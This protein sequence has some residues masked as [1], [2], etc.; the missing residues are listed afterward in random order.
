MPR[1]AVPEKDKSGNKAMVAQSENQDGWIKVGKRKSQCATQKYVKFDAQ[2]ASKSHRS[3]PPIKNAALACLTD[4]I[5]DRSRVFSEV[6]TPEHPLFSRSENKEGTP[7]VGVDGVAEEVEKGKN[8]VPPG[9]SYGLGVPAPFRELAI[10]VEASDLGP[11]I[12]A[13]D[14]GD[15]ALA[16]AIT[17]DVAGDGIAILGDTPSRLPLKGVVSGADEGRPGNDVEKGSDVNAN[18]VSCEVEYE[19]SRVGTLESNLASNLSCLPPVAKD[20]VD[21]RKEA[22]WAGDCAKQV[23]EKLGQVALAPKVFDKMPKLNPETAFAASR[24]DANIPKEPNVLA[25]NL[26]EV[27]EDH[28]GNDECKSAISGVNLS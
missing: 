1:V 14:F 13:P 10:Q 17:D 23:G 28:I 12:Q 27:G 20:V 22:S 21:C 26:G 19:V 4:A 16:K 6:Q 25:T 5:H 9:A 15:T 3:V 11:T 7:S 18:G 8:E 2:P 24:S